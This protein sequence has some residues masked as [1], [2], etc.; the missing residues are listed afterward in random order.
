MRALCLL[1]SQLRPFVFTG[2]AKEGGLP[3]P[4]Q[5]GYLDPSWQYPEHKSEEATDV[6]HPRLMELHG[7]PAFE[8]G[9]F[10][11]RFYT[12]LSESI[13][14]RREAQAAS[15]ASSGSSSSSSPSAAGGARGSGVGSGG[16][17]G[18][19]GLGRK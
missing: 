6:A 14:E 13:R 16:V 15:A 10:N 1:R 2:T 17:L 4:S 11:P 7:V 8:A 3:Q 5:P 9:R 12:A 18:R 19:F